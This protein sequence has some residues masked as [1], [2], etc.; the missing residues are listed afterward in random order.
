MKNYIPQYVY[1]LKRDDGWKKLTG[2]LPVRM[3]NDY[4]FRALLQSDN[5]TLKGL[6]TVIPLPII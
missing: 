5:E 1:P 3:T 6:F 2:S 4:L